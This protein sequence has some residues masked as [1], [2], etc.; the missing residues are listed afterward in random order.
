MVE[1]SFGGVWPQQRLLDEDVSFV[2]K[3]PALILRNDRPEGTHLEAPRQCTGRCHL[4]QELN[5][6]V[7]VQV[8]IR[9]GQLHPVVFGD[10]GDAISLRIEAF[11]SVGQILNGVGGGLGILGRE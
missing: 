3:D 2:E 4:D 7:G 11:K 9:H 1:F 6:E 10:A 5:E 8:D